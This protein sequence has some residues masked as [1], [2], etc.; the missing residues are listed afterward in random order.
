MNNMFQRQLGKISETLTLFG[1]GI[2]L[3]EGD[4]KPLESAV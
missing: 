1:V 3:R 4:K 2:H